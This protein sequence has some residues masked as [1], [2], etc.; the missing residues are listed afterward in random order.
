MHTDVVPDPENVGIE[1]VN[2]G[3]E[4]V[5]RCGGWLLG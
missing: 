1:G 4:G 2:M 3:M 5:D